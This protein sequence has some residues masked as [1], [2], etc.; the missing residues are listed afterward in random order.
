MAR[1]HVANP[2]TSAMAPVNREMR[3]PP[4]AI[5]SA[6]IAAVMTNVIRVSMSPAAMRTA[7]GA[8]QLS[9]QAAPNR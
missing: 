1:R 2:A 9:T 8:A 6:L 5:R 3:A 7:M 4:G